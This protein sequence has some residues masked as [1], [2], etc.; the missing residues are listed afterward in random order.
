MGSR[1]SVTQ[2]KVDAAPLRPDP[3]LRDQGAT[4]VAI[5]S[6]RPA[7]AAATC[8]RAGDAR[9]R[10]RPRPPAARPDASP[11]ARRR[12]AP[13]RGGARPRPRRARASRSPRRA[14]RRPGA[15]A[16]SVP[17]AHR[18]PA[19]ADV[20]ERR[21]HRLG[22]RRRRR[23]AQGRAVARRALP[24]GRAEELAGH[25]V[26]GRAGERAG[27]VEQDDGRAPRGQPAG[28]VERA[29]DGVEQPA[30]LAAR[31]RGALLP[32]DAVARPLCLQ[33]RELARPPRAGRPP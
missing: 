5:S 9:R 26:E 1:V 20:D 7:S 4:D 31:D 15:A 6:A 3:G 12:A 25:G 2:G 22:E 18:R 8:Q 33:Q 24:A 32:A 17:R 13:T 14:A 30:P 29:V 21:H 19:A 23:H 10:R 16:A 11:T 27:R 28:V